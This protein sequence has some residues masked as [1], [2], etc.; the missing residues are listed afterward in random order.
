MSDQL[1]GEE[2]QK[3]QTS[4][5]DVAQK[6]MDTA[7]KVKDTADK[8][9]KIQKAAKAGKAVGKGGK[10]LSALGPALPYIGIALLV[11][12]I[13]I[14]LIG[15]IVFLLTMPGMVMEQL[16]AL[17]H[18]LGNKV[19]A[20]FGADTTQQIED[21]E[22]FEVL[23]YLEDM[24]YDLKGYGFLTEFYDESDTD[25]I[26]EAENNS[27]EEDTGEPDNGVIRSSE[28]GKIIGAK[29]EVIFTYIMSDNYVY[30]CKNFNIINKASNKGGFWNKLWGGIVALG[31]KLASIFVEEGSLWG[32]GMIYLENPNGG[33]WDNGIFDKITIDAATKTMRIK[34][35][36][37]ANA[38]EYDLEGWTGRYGMPLEFLL[39]VHIASNMP[40]L[41]YDMV[42]F[43]GTEV[44]IRLMDATADVDAEYRSPTGNRVKYNDMWEIKNEG[45][46][47][48]DGWVLSDEEAFAVLA[49]GIESPE[50]CLGIGREGEDGT[51]KSVGYPEQ[52][53]VDGETKENIN[54]D[55]S[56]QYKTMMEMFTEYGFTGTSELPLAIYTEYKLKQL[57]IDLTDQKIQEEAGYGEDY[58]NQMKAYA[59]SGEYYIGSKYIE[60]SWEGVEKETNE[61]CTYYTTVN[62]SMTVY[63]DYAKTIIIA[64]G[65]IRRSFT[66]SERSSLVEAGK[67]DLLENGKSQEEVDAMSDND[68]LGTTTCSVAARN[69]NTDATKCCSVCKEHIKK[70]MA[71]AGDVYEEDMSTFVPYLRKVTDHWYRDVYLELDSGETVD[72]IEIDEEYEVFMDERWTNYEVYPDDDEF[73]GNTVWYIIGKDGHFI[74][75]DAESA[76]TVTDS[77]LPM[78]ESKVVAG[79][80]GYLYYHVETAKEAKEVG[81]SVARMAITNEFSGSSWSAYDPDKTATDSSEWTQAYPNDE[82]PI[83]RRVYVQTTVKGGKIQI[84]DGIRGVTNEKIKRIFAVNTYFRYDGNVDTAE[85]IYALREKLSTENSRFFGNLNGDKG[86]DSKYNP[87]LSKG[88]PET[89]AAN[90]EV[91][92]DVAVGS[93]STTN[94]YKIKDYSA[95]LDLTKESL[96]AFSMLENTHT[97]DADYIYRDFKELIV[98]LGYFDK[99]EFAE[100]VPEVFEWFIPEIG[101]YGYPIRY[102]DKKENLYGTMA[103]SYDDYKALLSLSVMS[104]IPNEAPNTEEGAGAYRVTDREENEEEEENPNAGIIQKPE[105]ESG[106]GSKTLNDKE[107]DKTPSG[108]RGT[109]AALVTLEEFLST[110]REMCEYINAEGYDYCVY[111]PE[112]GGGDY[113]ADCTCSSHQPC[114]DEYKELGRSW[115]CNATGCDCGT[116]HCKHNVHEND[117]G[118]PTTFEGSK[119]AGEHNFCCATLVSWA[120]QNVEVMPDED[121]LDGAESL[122]NYVENVLGAKKIEKSQ[123]LEEGDI[124]VYFGHV[125]L[126]GEK[127]DGGFVKYN[128]GHHVPIGATEG[129][130]S[131]VRYGGSCIEHI[132]GWPEKAEYA[133]RLNWGG[134]E[135]GVYE[136]YKGNEAVVSPATGIL[137]EYGTYEGLK[138]EYSAVNDDTLITVDGQAPENITPEEKG[139]RLNY[140]LRY[141]VSGMAGAGIQSN[142]TEG[143]TQVGTDATLTEIKPRDVY[144]KVGYA[145]I[146]VLNDD[147]FKELE[148]ALGTPFGDSLQ[149]ENGY[150]D[151]NDLTQET[152]REW[153]EE[154][155]DVY[156]YKEFIEI[157][158]SFDLESHIIYIDGFECELPDPAYDPDMIYEEIPDG[159]AL[160]MSYFKEH[161]DE[162]EDSMYEVPD[163]YQLSSQKATDRNKAEEEVKVGA[164][165]LMVIN[166]KLFIKEGTVIGRT[167]TDKETVEARGETFTPPPSDEELAKMKEEGKTYQRTVVGNYIRIVMRDRDD[168]VVENVEGYLKLDEMIPMPDLEMEKFLYWMG[169]YVEG[170]NKYQSGGQWMSKAVDLN[171]GVGATHFFGLTKYCKPN[172]EALGYTVDDW[173]ADLPMEMLVNVYLARIEEDKKYVQDELGA[174]IPDGYL[175]AF[176]SVKHNYGNLTKR[177]DEYKARGEVAESTWTTYEG[178]QYAEALTKRRISEWMIITEGKYTECYSDPYKEL[179]FES[180]TPFTDWC[181]EL[182]ITI[183]VG[184]TEE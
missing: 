69:G 136:G 5:S 127:K 31:Q 15:I 163:I 16:K 19:A 29:S 147:L 6:G 120:L 76:R 70:I 101:S 171:D 66:E 28:S 134:K 89:L 117:C 23:D 8:V 159:E 168:T 124:L 49:L 182:G 33:E 97:Q 45:W 73:A 107:K 98:E 131:D 56:N 13:I 114:M 27:P 137:L 80:D 111:E 25:I 172:A 43:F 180:E 133:L 153:T 128:G 126:V 116:N 30:T 72:G 95:Q 100:N 139:D 183:T 38:F 156:G 41:A 46:I 85:I 176:I 57:M 40:D 36:W 21:E 129:Q 154:Q 170:G 123:E 113:R 54:T 55:L 7:R 3:K 164:S 88:D 177:G 20:F 105:A 178:T 14:F 110:T 143:D 152:V 174:D 142:A 53:N 71:A 65:E 10:I 144:D 42:S 1:M 91:T 109:A 148:T 106:G 2:K 47:F 52:V 146:L 112:P 173:G 125:D 9:D 102:A 94:T 22:V 122:A 24:G 32:K 132:S 167:R 181:K 87:D 64:P 149:L 12:L 104:T 74:T 96:A 151:Y 84:E 108:K 68:I 77:T 79:K 75:S 165:P 62:F 59:E 78:D 160:S 150:K 34:R 93:D 58:V 130:P 135:E 61:P 4:V 39:S 60:V 86:G 63:P 140:D 157:Y 11:I 26:T 179:V 119:A 81:L 18:E 51:S 90:L 141:P 44:V 166:D 115:I 138:A 158:D 37:F 99:E 17:F 48:T 155:I 121:H 103:H 118:L 67:A 162:Y 145:K 184:S 50:G 161:A 83:K 35:G 175:Q 92:A 169:V 82:D